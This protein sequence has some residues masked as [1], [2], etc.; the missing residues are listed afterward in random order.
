MNLETFLGSHDASNPSNSSFLN[1]SQ[2]TFGANQ[3]IPFLFHPPAVSKPTQ[4]HA[5]A[6]PPQFSPS[7]AFPLPEEVKDID[8]T[9]ISPFRNGEETSGMETSEDSVRPVATGGLRRVFKQRNKRHET[10]LITQ[11][12][13]LQEEEDPAS[14][15][16]SDENEEPIPVNQMTSHHYTLNMPAPAPAPSELPYILLGRVLYP[17]SMNI[18]LIYD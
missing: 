1:A 8:M 16:E 12:H 2:P 10:R 3:N 9:D 6:P 17:G 18:D 5:W 4:S 15:A 14:A 11:R 7:K 13:H